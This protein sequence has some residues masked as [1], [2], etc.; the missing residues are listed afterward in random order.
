M[1]PK[2][3]TI[4]SVYKNDDPEY[5]SE[6]V[7]SLLDQTLLP[8]EI[9]ITVDGPVGKG[10]EKVLNSF[11]EYDVINIHKLPENVGRGKARHIAITSAKF[12]YI[13]MMDADD[14]SKKDRFEKQMKKIRDSDADIIGSYIEEFEKFPGDTKI[15]R[16]V[17]ITHEQIMKFAKWKQPMNH[18]TILFKRQA[19]LG[20]GGYR[21]FRMLEDFEL[22]HRMILS[23]MRFANIPEVL[24]Y[25][26]FAEENQSKRSGM[27]YFKEEYQILKE[28]RKSGHMNSIQFMFSFLIR[29]ITRIMPLGIA[30][31]FYKY[32][33]R[34]RD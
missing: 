20:T 34:Y 31:K 25:V 2:L 4:I 11:A 3:S 17:P 5:F 24:V 15:I 6:A 32:I 33:L 22:F 23:G 28:M 21:G 13:A 8:D 9:L 27:R 7:Q 19:Y 26:R 30:N 29:L 14:I 10:I 12:E 16:K 1:S 18:V